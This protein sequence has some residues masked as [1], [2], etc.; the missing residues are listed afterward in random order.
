LDDVMR[1]EYT[2]WSGERGYTAE[3]FARTAS[4]AAGVDVAPL[5]HTLAASTAEI[6]YSQMLDWFGL[7]FVPG[8]PARAWTLEIDP[9]ATPPQRRHLAAFLAH[10]RD[11]RHPAP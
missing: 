8:D 11:G 4:D 2:R 7:R 6:D 3:E 10:S 9:A 5:I 1:L